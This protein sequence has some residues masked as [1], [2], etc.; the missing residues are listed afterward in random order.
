MLPFCSH[1]EDE[2]GLSVTLKPEEG[3]ET[4]QEEANCI[5][6]PTQSTANLG[7]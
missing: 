1:D 3:Q 4:E 7:T 2:Q 5:H 6:T